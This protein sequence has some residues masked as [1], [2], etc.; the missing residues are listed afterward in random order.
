M[1][2]IAH[3]VVC[4]NKLLKID[5]EDYLCEPGENIIEAEACTVFVQWKLK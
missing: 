5:F 3:I 2:L 1:I 4:L